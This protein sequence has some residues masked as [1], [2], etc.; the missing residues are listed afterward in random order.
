[1]KRHLR[2]VFGTALGTLITACGLS[3]F[4]VPNRMNDGGLTGL[5]VLLHYLLHWPIGAL[6]FVLN[7]PLLA[8]VSYLI[9]LPFVFRTL[10]G[11]TFLS[12]WLAIL[13]EHAVTHDLLLAALYGGVLSGTGLGV[14]FRV[15]GSTGGTD[16]VA[17]LLRH[18]TNT[19]MG[20]GLLGTDAVIIASTALFFGLRLGMY[21]AVA[22]FVGTRVVDLIQEGI[23]FRRE[24]LVISEQGEAIAKEVLQRMGRGV[25]LLSGRGAYTDTERPVLLIVISRSEVQDLKDIVYRMDRDAFLIITTAHEVLG[26]GFKELQSRRRPGFRKEI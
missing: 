7:V 3:F 15:G 26:E 16:L 20:A 18:F 9:G 24:A 5:A 17:R 13:P 23:D 4:L 2:D 10:L 25:T 21:S 22:L 12:V 14:V 8:A 19:S 11:V 1:M 6:V